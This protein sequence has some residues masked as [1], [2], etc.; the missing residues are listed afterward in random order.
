ME[1][2][3]I[4]NEQ[5][6]EQAAEVVVSK[7]GVNWGKIGFTALVAGAVI[8]LGFKVAKTV[9]A[10]FKAEEEDTYEE[11]EASDHDFVDA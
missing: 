6:I 8:A 10:K 1:N 5:A 3:I 7:N 2:E 11:D 4:M 9:K